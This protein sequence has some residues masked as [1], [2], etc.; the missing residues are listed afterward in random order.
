MSMSASN[1]SR[2]LHRKRSA[3][4]SLAMLLVLGIAIILIGVCAI[5][6]DVTHNIS[7][8]TA[9]QNASDAAALGGAATL[10]RQQTDPSDHSLTTAVANAAAAS[11]LSVAGT[12][13]ADGKAVSANTPGCSVQPT[14]IQP[15]SPNPN[16]NCPSNN[17]QVKVAA[18]MPVQNFFAK[19]FGHDTDNVRVE[20][21]ATAYSTVKTVYG[22]GV[23]PLAVSL[24][25][26]N[27]HAGVAGDDVLYKCNIGDTETFTLSEPCANAAWTSLNAENGSGRDHSAAWL[28]SAIDS[29]LGLNY[30]PS[31][32]PAQSVGEVSDAGVVGIDLLADMSTDGSTS[33]KDLSQGAVYQALL[34]QTLVLPV[35]AGDPPYRNPAAGT[36]YQPQAQSRP[37]VGFVGFK[38]TEVGTANGALQYIKGT[39]TKALVKGEPGIVNP[40][41]SLDPNTNDDLDKALNR[42]SPGII[43]L[44]DSHMLNDEDNIV[45]AQFTDE[46]SA[47][48]GSLGGGAGGAADDTTGTPANGIPGY[49]ARLLTA[50][51]VAKETKM[52]GEADRGYSQLTAYPN[53]SFDVQC[54]YHDES[55]ISTQHPPVVQLLGF[56]NGVDGSQGTYVIDSSDVTDIANYRGD[57]TVNTITLPNNSVKTKFGDTDYESIIQVTVPPQ[58]PGPFLIM[59]IAYDGDHVE[60]QG[61]HI[62]AISNPENV[63]GG[64]GCLGAGA[65]PD[66]A[67]DPTPGPM[68]AQPPPP[69]RHPHPKP[70]KDPKPGAHPPPHPHP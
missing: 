31:A 55:P 50:N 32:I 22:N 23:F 67:P 28:N 16:Q 25:T 68:L 37:L 5:G 34:N 43:Q 60:D 2:Q 46:F 35:M 38:V 48:T 41:V 52:L 17:G 44:A 26:I 1:P 57:I 12:N 13:I 58:P 63:N 51:G 18:V 42:L 65:D 69:P 15:G 27:G 24:D 9:L 61:R 66:G 3:T 20:S 70:P 54:L 53:Q 62:W 14:V 56:V 40:V 59:L 7:V 64:R 4:G 21:V 36:Q 19:L 11:A 6:F 33:V 47:G 39:I 49:I 29:A 30:S 8:R 10:V 45:G